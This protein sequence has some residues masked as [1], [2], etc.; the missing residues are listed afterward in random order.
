M[1]KMLK[2]MQIYQEHTFWVF[3]VFC[4]C[5]SKILQKW[6]AAILSKKFKFTKEAMDQNPFPYSNQI[7]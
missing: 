1:L 6:V 3:V 4:Y 7:K 2:T 5:F